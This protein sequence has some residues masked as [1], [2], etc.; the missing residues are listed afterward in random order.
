MTQEMD[1]G[2]NHKLDWFFSEYVYG[3]QLPSYK[4]DSSFETAPDG[5]I[6]LNFTL[7]QSNVDTKFAMLVPIYLELDDGKIAFLGRSRMLGATTHSQKVPLKGLKTKPRR[8]MINYY[9]DVLA[10]N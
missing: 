7:A 1:I 9:D 6:V 5:T 3:T 2:G 10:S 8:A 4:F